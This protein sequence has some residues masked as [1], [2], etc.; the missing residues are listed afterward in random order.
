MSI[1]SKIFGT[2]SDREIKKILPLVEKINNYYNSIENY[3][4]ADLQNRTQEIKEEIQQKILSTENEKEVLDSYV[5]ETFAMVKHACRL[6]V[7]KEWEVVGQVI[8]W[9]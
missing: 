9:E 5:I 2:K 7:G 6:L 8:K 3:T 1:L 4:E